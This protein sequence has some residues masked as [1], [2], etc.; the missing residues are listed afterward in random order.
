MYGRAM[1][2]C[3]TVTIVRSTP[4]QT[5]YGIP[6]SMMH[7]ETTGTTVFVVVVK[8]WKLSEQDERSVSS[9]PAPECRERREY[10]SRVTQVER[11]THS[12]ASSS[13]ERSS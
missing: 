8:N 12:I 13:T 6:Y 3:A 9:M 11:K 7:C 10:E 1:E 5:P 4:L 2:V